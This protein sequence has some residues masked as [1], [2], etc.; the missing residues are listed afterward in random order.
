MEVIQD[1]LTLQ[2]ESL[3]SKNAELALLYGQPQQSFLTMMSPG[4]DD[5]RSLTSVSV[6]PEVFNY[7]HTVQYM[8][9]NPWAYDQQQIAQQR[10]YEVDHPAEYHDF[11]DRGYLLSCD[12]IESVESVVETR[13]ERHLR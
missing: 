4:T 3:E 13:Q 6:E 2:L 5:S 7:G 11:G 1:L 10:A 9:R 8:L 12:S